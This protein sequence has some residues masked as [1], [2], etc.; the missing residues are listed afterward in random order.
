M[1]SA[2]QLLAFL[3]LS[4]ASDNTSR[5]WIFFEIAATLRC[6]KARKIA[7]M[8]G[9]SGTGHSC[10]PF[11]SNISKTFFPVLVIR[12]NILENKYT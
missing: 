2:L 3:L 11:L 6:K 10:Y 1:Y 12:A 7:R 8:V 5:T 4:H 9:I